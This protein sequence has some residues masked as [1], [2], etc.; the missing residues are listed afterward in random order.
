VKL[1]LG[2]LD[3]KETLIKEAVEYRANIAMQAPRFFQASARFI[4]QHG[5][6]KQQDLT[7]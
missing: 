4:H 3:S 2:L 6:V 7:L 1:E 5:T